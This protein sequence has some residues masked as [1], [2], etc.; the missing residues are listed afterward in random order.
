MSR[1]LPLNLLIPQ[2]SLTSFVVPVWKEFPDKQP[3]ESQMSFILSL[4]WFRALLHFTKMGYYCC[5]D[6]ASPSPFFQWVPFVRRLKKGPRSLQTSQGP[7]P[8][9]LHRGI[10]LHVYGRNEGSEMFTQLNQIPTSFPI[11]PP[12]TSCYINIIFRVSAPLLCST[13]GFLWIKTLR[14]LVNSYLVG[15]LL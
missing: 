12:H 9:H 4:Q 14:K 13:Q 11:S 7:E 1:V 2:T 8:C 3:P 10:P 15:Y 6:A 5:L